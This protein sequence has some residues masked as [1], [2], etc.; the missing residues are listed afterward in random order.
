MKKG[1]QDL[2]VSKER[3]FVLKLTA[4]LPHMMQLKLHLFVSSKTILLGAESSLFLPSRNSLRLSAL[5]ACCSSVSG[6]LKRISVFI[7]ASRVF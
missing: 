6:V 1:S 4:S 2:T 5:L 3:S 7:Y